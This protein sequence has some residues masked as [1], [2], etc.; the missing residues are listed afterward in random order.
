MKG[1]GDMNWVETLN[2]ALDY[3]EENLL[4]NITSSIIADHVYISCAHLQRSFFCLTGLTINEYIRNRRLTLAGHDLSAKKGNV[5]DIAMKY[6]Y[7]TPESFSKA[8]NR[9]HNVTPIQVKRN[10]VNL[11]SY[12]RLTVKIIMEG[13]STMD[14]RI[15]KKN[16]FKVVVKVKSFKDNSFNLDESINDVPTSWDEYYSQGLHEKVAP[17]L[18]VCGE[19][20]QNTK[21]F[22]YGIGDFYESVTMKPDDFEIWT[23]PAHTW[24]VFKC[25]G[26]MPD[27]FEKIWKRVYSEWLPQANYELI[28]S[29]DFEYYTEGDKGSPDYISELWI[30]V[31]EK[32]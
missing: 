4:E 19:M 31:K 1:G 21:T 3:I 29:Y 25:V 24:A 27:A 6:G 14:Y 13:G 18:G 15:E 26:A 22:R 2:K 11:K 16:E 23:I 30:P 5:I 17:V 8:F 7:E 32:Q 9:F 10:G 28:P 20:D 12:N